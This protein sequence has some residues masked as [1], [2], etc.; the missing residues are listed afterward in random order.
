M[1][2]YKTIEDAI[3]ALTEKYGLRI[4][5]NTNRFIALLSDFAPNLLEEQ[6]IIRLF[7]RAGGYE[8]IH[9]GVPGQTPAVLF[10]T[11][12]EKAVCSTKDIDQQGFLVR[13]NLNILKQID[14][15]IVNALN[16]DEVFSQGMNY[17]RAFPKDKNIPVALL[18]FDEASKLG[19]PNGLLYISSSYIKGKGV[20]KDTAKGIK[21]LE[22][23]AA[24]GNKRAI[25]ELARILC[26]GQFVEKNTARAV[27]LLKAV[28]DPSALFMLGDIYKANNEYVK[29]IDCYRQA[30]EQGHV[31]AQYSTAI[32]YATGQGTKRDIQTAKKWLKS[33]ASL[34]HGEARRKLEELGE[35]WD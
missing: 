1:I 25:L 34:G 22:L 5:S 32:A 29:A 17:F 9:K 15:R 7:A 30:A 8:A 3:V 23:S 2:Q 14:S 21:A 12:C 18:L 20:P 31:Y 35:K 27:T 16:G 4:L 19:N 13:V 26:E 10:A 6:R 11:I 33:A 28:D 24:T